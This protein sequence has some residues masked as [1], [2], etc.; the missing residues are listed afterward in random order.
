MSLEEQD[1]EP[2][3]PLRRPGALRPQERRTLS[4]KAQAP[5]GSETLLVTTSSGSHAPD[6]SSLEGCSAGAVP[7]PPPPPTPTVTLPLISRCI[8]QWYV[9]VP[10][11][12]KATV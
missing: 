10:R 11:P 8:A 5:H 6:M 12:S 3:G 9:T 1:P 7:P 2:G 4:S